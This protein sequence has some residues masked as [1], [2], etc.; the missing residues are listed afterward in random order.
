MTRGRPRV[1]LDAMRSMASSRPRPSSASRCLRSRRAA[2]P[3]TRRRPA[4]PEPR[5]RRTAISPTSAR[6]GPLAVGKPPPDFTGT[7]QDGVEIKLSALKGSRRHLLLPQGRDAGLHRGGQGLPRRVERARE[8]GAIVIGIST[9][10]PAVPP[11][12]CEAPRSSVPPGERRERRNRPILR[13]AEPHRISRRQTFVIGPDGNVKRGLSRRRRLEARKRRSS[14]ISRHEGA[15][16]PPVHAPRRRL[17]VLVDG[18]PMADEEA[19]TSGT[20]SAAGWR[21]VAGTPR[22]R[23]ARGI[24]SVHPG[25]DGD[26]PVLRAEQDRRAAS[27]CAGPRRSALGRC[28]VDSPA[29]HDGPDKPNRSPNNPRNF[30]KKRHQ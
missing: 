17:G 22:L 25:V 27:L 19:P 8:E 21:T 16:F 29:R 3:R 23:R 28:P 26:R 5:P 18:T 6:R 2:A 24:R 20:A 15:K 13:G 14:R 4:L 7:D 12:V 9:D 30:A 10:T 1:C 11:G